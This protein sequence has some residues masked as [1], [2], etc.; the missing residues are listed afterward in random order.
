MVFILLIA[1]LLV[2]GLFLPDEYYVEQSI[3]IKAP[4]DAV[5]SQVNNMRKW[6]E[7]SPMRAQDPHV[8]LSFGGA[9]SGIGASMAWE[10]EVKT[11]G[12]GSV[13]IIE[14]KPYHYIRS[15]HVMSSGEEAT[16]TWLFRST[17][18]ETEVIWSQTGELGF[19]PAN[20]YLGLLKE[21]VMQKQFELGLVGLKKHVESMAH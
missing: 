6:V 1:G 3:R 9:S 4:K 21:R 15:K 10:S 11:L 2:G 17:G 20:R 5:F 16:G 7:W 14:S 13:T 8:R 12:S 19:N 18:E